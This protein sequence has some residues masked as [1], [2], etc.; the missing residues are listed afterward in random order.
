MREEDQNHASRNKDR[1]STSTASSSQDQLSERSSR[2]RKLNYVDPNDDYS[3]IGDFSDSGSNWEPNSDEDSNVS[4]GGRSF[5][6]NNEIMNVNSTGVE[7]V[8]TSA[9]IAEATENLGNQLSITHADIPDLS[10][11]GDSEPTGTSIT[12]APNEMNTPNSENI[13]IGGA[14]ISN[15]VVNGKYFFMAQPFFVF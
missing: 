13:L 10:V 6:T 14:N 2:K 1:P 4:D 11:G 12:N 9:Q 5:H 8:E 7:T 3:D 15:E